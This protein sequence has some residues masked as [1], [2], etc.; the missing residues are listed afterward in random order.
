MQSSLPP[1][2]ALVPAAGTASRLGAIPSSKELILLAQK[3]PSGESILSTPLDRALDEVAEAR[4]EQA[5]VLVRRGKW[6]IPDYLSRRRQGAPLVAYLILDQTRSLVETLLAA[7][8]FAGGRPVVLALP[9]ILL[10]PR[11]TLTRLLTNLTTG[12]ADLVLGAFPTA[13]PELSDVVHT[14]RDGVVRRLQVKCSRADATL[15]WATAAWR[16]SLWPHLRRSLA[17]SMDCDSELHLGH[18][19]QAA[20]DAGCRVESV[21]FVEGGFTDLGN[22]AALSAALPKAVI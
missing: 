19:F 14:G 10:T 7:E 11:G 12:T 2:I 13:H 5:L 21:P 22:L 6:D 17:A 9:D 20:I 8:A 4:I 18:A 15:A 16:P 1:P 3:S